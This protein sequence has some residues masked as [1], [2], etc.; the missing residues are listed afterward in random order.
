MTINSSSPLE[1]VLAKQRKNALQISLT[2][3]VITGLIAIYYSFFG[4]VEANQWTI[5]SANT[6]ALIISI[7]SLLS[8]LLNRR[9]HSQLG[10][11]LFLGAFSFSLTMV[12]LFSGGMDVLLIS[13]ILVVVFGVASATLPRKTANRAVQGSFLLALL[14][15]A[16]SYFEPFERTYKTMSNLEK[17]VGNNTF[18]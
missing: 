13:L 7:F 14:F 11:M 5:S 15:I 1:Q 17:K 3:F 2:T 16:I 4:L 12:S 10:I 18:R 6:L 9:G 8:L